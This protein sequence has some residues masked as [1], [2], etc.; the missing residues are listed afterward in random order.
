[1]YNMRLSGDFFSRTNI[2]QKILLLSSVDNIS[3]A[4]MG[5]NHLMWIPVKDNGRMSFGHVNIIIAL[6]RD[7]N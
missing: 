5:N 2:L 7:I 4:R 6:L 1:M 3:V